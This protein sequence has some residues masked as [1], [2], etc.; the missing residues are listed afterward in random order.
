M[1]RG[2]EQEDENVSVSYNIKDQFP[3]NWYKDI[4]ARLGIG[5]TL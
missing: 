4:I 3:L 5:M 2:T 1:H